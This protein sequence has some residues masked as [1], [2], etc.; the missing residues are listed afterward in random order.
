MPRSTNVSWI[1]SPRCQEMILQQYSVSI[2]M[3]I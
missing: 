3:P 2:Q 1:T